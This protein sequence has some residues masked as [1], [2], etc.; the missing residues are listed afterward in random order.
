MFK[1]LGELAVTLANQAY[2]KSY[3]IAA[4]IKTT[5]N[6]Q[7]YERKKHGKKQRGFVAKITACTNLGKS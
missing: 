4:F 2:V 6:K 7:K 5:E 1:L 3:T